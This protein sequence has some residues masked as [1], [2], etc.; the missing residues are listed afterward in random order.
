[1][2]SRLLLM[3]SLKFHNQQGFIFIETAISLPIISIILVS[4]AMI[5]WQGWK[6]YRA[7]V[8]DWILQEEIFH[9][10]QHITAHVS[11]VQRYKKADGTFQ[12][13]LTISTLANGFDKLEV[14]AGILNVSNH[15]SRYERVVEITR[16]IV[17]LDDE[18]NF[19]IYANSTTQ[20]LTGRNVLFGR[21]AITKFKCILKRP[22]L[23]RI[24]LRGKNWTTKHEYEI[25]TEIFL[26]NMEH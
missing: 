6:L 12:N 18:N 14:R 16:Y 24:E 3:K 9:A 26:K 13:G 20:P 10:M 7:E 5:F 8:A 4:T 23:L 22:D 15:A 2:R 11:E 19:Q 25:A 17:D 1:M 21:V